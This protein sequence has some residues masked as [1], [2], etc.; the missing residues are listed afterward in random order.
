MKTDDQSRMPPALPPGSRPCWCM[1]E[2]PSPSPRWFAP[3]SWLG[4]A[5]RCTRLRRDAV[6]APGAAARP[7]SALGRRRGHHA[8]GRRRGRVPDDEAVGAGGADQQHGS[9]RHRA[10]A[11]VVAPSAKP[12]RAYES[13][14]VRTRGH[15]GRRF[16]CRTGP[17]KVSVP[18]HRTAVAGKHDGGPEEGIDLL[19]RARQSDALGDYAAVL[20]IVAE[21]ERRHPAGRLS[22][23]REVLRV[24]ALVGL[25]RGGEARHAAASFRRQFPRSVLLQTIDEMLASMP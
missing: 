16:R 24:K 15:R 9:A 23:E 22:E 17:P 20:A 19:I 4:R 21:H 7:P 3:A 10:R 13:R 11:P 25:G 5:R 14:R 12:G 18:S 2:C 8:H 6:V 1:S